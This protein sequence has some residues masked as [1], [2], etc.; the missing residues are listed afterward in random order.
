MVPDLRTSQ[1][2][3]ILSVSPTPHAPLLL[4]PA[5]KSNSLVVWA[6]TFSE[7]FW[8]RGPQGARVFVAQPGPSHWRV[9]GVHSSA[10]LL[11]SLSA[12]PRT[13]HP[14]ALPCPLFCLPW[15]LFNDHCSL[16]RVPLALWPPT[17]FIIS[18]ACPFLLSMPQGSSQQTPFPPASSE[19]PQNFSASLARRW[20]ATHSRNPASSHLSSPIGTDTRPFLLG[21]KDLW[22][23]FTLNLSSSNAK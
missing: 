9:L 8:L 4:L 14:Q 10:C 18:P 16:S 21:A 5:V 19:G 11:C 22:V 2:P 3:T 13:P 1:G 12:F 20:C 17:P 6:L 15:F 7:Y 23:L